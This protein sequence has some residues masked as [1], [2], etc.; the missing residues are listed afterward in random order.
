LRDRKGA[1]AAA[2]DLR[3]NDVNSFVWIGELA[4]V[5][6]QCRSRQGDRSAAK[7][8][9][10]VARFFDDLARQYA[11]NGLPRRPFRGPI[12]A[13]L[14]RDVTLV[15]PSSDVA[16][17]LSA[18]VS[19]VR[20]RFFPTA[21]LEEVKTG[22]TPSLKPTGL[23]LYGSPTSNPLIGKIMEASGWRVSS[24]E[25]AVGGQV[26]RGKHLILIACRAQ[27]DDPTRGVVVYTA[28]NDDDLLKVNRVFH[29]PTDWVVA[30]RL[31]SGEFE[32]VATGDFPKKGI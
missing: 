12:N 9:S 13:V 18:Y 27:S 17:S 7:C 20:R 30:R 11:A 28:A 26:F 10:D 21:P 29:G 25:V 6:A 24:D 14:T 1:D 23:V 31:A 3:N 5:L 16:P 22:A 2:R 4:D 32:V 15:A 19:Q 8:V